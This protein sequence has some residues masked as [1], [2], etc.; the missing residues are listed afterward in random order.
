MSTAKV[1][2]LRARALQITH[3]C[4]GVAG[5]VGESKA[6]LG[7]TVTGFDF[8][9][10][11]EKLGQTDSTAPL[12]KFDPNY[13]PPQ[14]SQQKSGLDPTKAQLTGVSF[15]APSFNA[16]KLA[17][18]AIDQS[19]LKYDATGIQNNPDVR[20]AAL[21]TLRAESRKAVLDKAV[22]A[23]QNVFY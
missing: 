17:A 16:P 20:A 1:I 7:S 8:K 4:F 13:I 22:S 12:S 3:L 18:E 21:V 15:N 11:Y 23:R 2:S 10:F 5:I 19:R 9:A 6:Q 14:T